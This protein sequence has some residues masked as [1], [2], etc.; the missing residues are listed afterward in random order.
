MAEKSKEVNPNE[1]E[2]VTGGVVMP[3]ICR[4]KK[5]SVYQF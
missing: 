1:I 5:K 2:Q 3:G 4:H